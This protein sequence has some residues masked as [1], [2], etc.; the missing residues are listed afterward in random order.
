[1][2]K[3]KLTNDVIISNSSLEAKG[4]D[5]SNLLVSTSGTW[6]ATQ[7]CYAR[8]ANGHYDEI[9]I[10]NVAVNEKTGGMWFVC[11]KGDVLFGSNGIKAYALKS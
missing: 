2:S 11:N 1:M 5:P 6:T 10:N 4:I 8:M 9:K 7:D 3:I